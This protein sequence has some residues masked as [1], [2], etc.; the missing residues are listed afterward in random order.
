MKRIT[1]HYAPENLSGAANYL[2]KVGATPVLDKDR[3]ET[4]QTIH[5]IVVRKFEDAFKDEIVKPETI[6]GIL[7]A[8]IWKGLSCTFHAFDETTLNGIPENVSISENS[9][10]SISKIQVSFHINAALF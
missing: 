9:P 1:F 3:E 6:V 4:E 7:H 2:Q 5:D 8:G 10:D